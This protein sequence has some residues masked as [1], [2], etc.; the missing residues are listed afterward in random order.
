MKSQIRYSLILFIFIHLNTYSQ[1]AHTQQNPFTKISAHNFFVNQGDIFGTRVFIENRGQFECPEI[2]NRHIYYVLDEGNEKIY[3]TSVGLTYEF[4]KEKTFDE[5]EYEKSQKYADKEEAE[6]TKFVHMSWCNASTSTTELIPGEKQGHYFTY[7]EAKYNSSTF[8][9]LTYKNVY[10]NIDIE[11]TLPTQ[12]RTG[13]KYTVVLHPGADPANIK[14]L[15]DGDVKKIRLN[16][17]GEVSIKTSITS[18]VEHAPSSFYENGEAITCNFLLKHD[19]LCYNFPLNYNTNKTVIIDPWVSSASSL[20]INNLAYD[21][22]FDFGGHVFIYGGTLPVKVACYNFAGILMWT[23]GGAVVSQSWSSQPT[24][25][26][27]NFVVDKFTG[28]AYVGQGV[29]QS[30]SGS[31]VIRLNAAGVY[32]NFMSSPSPLNQE[33]WDMGFHCQGGNIFILGGGHTSNNSSATINTLT[34]N[35]TLSSF[36]PT[37]TGYVHDI[38]SHA[39][40]DAGNIFVYYSCSNSL[41]NNRICSVNASFNGNNWTVASGFTEMTEASNKTFYN[42]GASIAS[43][44]FNC[45]AANNWYV[46]YYDGYHIAAYSKSTG[47]LLASTTTS[48][49]ARR[50]G[51]I[52][53]DECNKLYL[54]GNGSI[55]TY[56]FNGSSFTMLAPITLSLTTSNQHVFDVKLNKGTQTIFASG[57]GFVGTYAAAGPSN[58]MSLTGPCNFNQF[59]IFINSSSVTCTSLGSATA[60]VTGG[61]GPFTYTWIPSNQTGSVATSIGIGNYTVLVSDS[62]TGS[63]YFATTSIASSNSLTG[64]ISSSGSLT[65][66]GASNGTAAIIGLTGGSGIQSYSWSNGISTQTTSFAS[67][68]NAGIYTVTVIDT[69]FGCQLVKSF[70]ITQPPPLTTTISVNP[71][72]PCTGS[73]ATLTSSPSGG[74]PGYI[75]FWTPISILSPLLS[76]QLV[77]QASPGTYI[78]WLTLTDANNCTISRSVS[79]TFVAP[80]QLSV[81]SVSICAGSSGSLTAS[82]ASSYTWQSNFV[83]STFIVSPLTNTIYAVTGTSLGCLSTA[84]VAALVFPP[85]VPTLSNNSPI[86]A[87]ATLH[88]SLTSGNSPSWIGPGGFSSTSLSPAIYQASTINSGIF[89][90]SAFNA[91]GCV[92][93]TSVNILVIP[94]PTLSAIGCTVC[95]NGALTL[96]AI[97]SQATDFLWSGPVGFSSFLQNPNYINPGS[98]RSGQYTVTIAT[99]GGCTNSAVATVTVTDLPEIVINSDGPKCMGSTVNFTATGG[100]IYQWNGPGGFNSILQNPSRFSVTSSASGFY[101]LTTNTGPCTTTSLYFLTLYSSPTPSATY[102]TPLCET[103]ALKLVSTN[104]SSMISYLWKGPQFSSSQPNPIRANSTPAFSG[105]YTLT[106]I[107]THSCSGSTTTYVTILPNPTITASGATVCLNE[108]CTISASGAVTYYWS[109]PQ[110]YQSNSPYAYIPSLSSERKGTYTVVGTAPNSCTNAATA[111]VFTKNLPKPHFQI[112]SKSKVCLNETF[113]LSGTGGI[114]YEWRNPTNTLYEGQTISIVAGKLNPSGMYTLK[115]TNEDGC[116]ATIDSL[117]ILRDLPKGILE[118]SKMEGCVP[119]C[120]NFIFSTVSDSL[121]R[122]STQI[123]VD[124]L[125]W[126]G[127]TFSH[128]FST[129]GSNKITVNLYDSL[130]T[131]S[132]AIDYFVAVFPRPKADFEFLPHN[133]IESLDE[134]QFTNTSLGE[135]QISWNW[136]LFAN[137]GPLSINQ[138]ASHLFREE[139]IYPIAL[140]VKN[141]W[142]CADTSMKPVRV[143]ED[144]FIYVPNVF[145]PNDDQLN[146]VFRAVGRGIKSFHMSIYNRWGDKL[147]ESKDVTYGWDAN[148]RGVPCKEDV[149]T[150]KMEVASVHGDNKIMTGHVSVLR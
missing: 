78:Y 79:L 1:S 126:P 20:S 120:S 96:N 147:F 68:L 10:P 61:I 118:G 108:P 148:Y 139:G 65:C 42:G 69:L 137:N 114:H 27:G 113:I 128:C 84:T 93:T 11:Y 132:N 123:V 19:T 21:I 73:S 141:K 2:K 112:L 38:T 39:L 72:M 48:L 47:I 91:M 124:G 25:Y 134:V 17:E 146:E 23:F 51:G 33:I 80:T 107:D 101:T 131:C 13:V 89:Q 90:V 135:G 127:N 145:T 60:N 106:V 121:T 136:Y 5:E 125:V 37:N 57:A 59:S 12:N 94:S 8:K 46:Y 34:A 14:I 26:I 111:Y 29:N 149:Y 71:I 104:D 100:I 44:G 41:L 92:G 18:L 76:T 117:I 129:E 70:S 75:H 77:S 102:N 140:V 64:T 143:S 144:F 43:N 82:G 9:K 88:F 74:T 66:W 54:G 22:D 55:L 97:A 122:I 81:S 15:Y 40:D 52:A 63:N 6:D 28:K 86:C 45:L 103:K 138:N 99:A 133:P 95:S 119:L 31:R 24:Y 30:I 35:M 98:N 50:Q 150:W 142:G 109:G 58:C 67:N 3:F 130:S 7:G 49:L 105:I 116:S 32:D 16:K 62:T 4:K 56:S 36:Q 53:V 110:S 83:G 115:V 85:F 87:G